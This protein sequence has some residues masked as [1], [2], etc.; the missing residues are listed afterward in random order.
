L[1]ERKVSPILPRF[2]NYQNIENDGSHE[3]EVP[4]RHLKPDLDFFF[5]NLAGGVEIAPM[6]AKWLYSILLL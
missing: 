3:L 4:I 1:A 2:E 5:S 6:N